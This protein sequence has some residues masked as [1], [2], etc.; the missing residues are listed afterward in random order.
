LV[1][2]RLAQIAIRTGQHDNISVG[3]TDPNFP[4]TGVRVHMRLDNDARAERA[5]ICDGAIEV[6]GFE[7]EQ[8]AMTGG[9]RVRIAKVGMVVIAPMVQLHQQLAVTDELLVFATA[10]GA[11]AA[12]QLLIPCTAGLN[13]PNG[14]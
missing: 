12:Q 3:V 11:L 2:L 9:R 6:V 7:P 4:M 5:G 13:V 14:D 8:D 10:M 1:F